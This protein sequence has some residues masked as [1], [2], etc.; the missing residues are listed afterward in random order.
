MTDQTDFRT[1]A[2]C[3]RTADSTAQL[4]ALEKSLDRLY[5]VGVST[6]SEFKRLDGLIFD[7]LARLEPSPLAT[8]ED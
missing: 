1:F 2:G 4:H 8:T 5:N 3:I 7:K 6:V